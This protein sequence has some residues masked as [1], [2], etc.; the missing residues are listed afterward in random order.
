MTEEAPK[1]TKEQ[2]ARQKAVRIRKSG[3]DDAYSWALFKDGYPI[4]RGM[5]RREA[6]WRRRRY[7]NEGVL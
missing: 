3:G 6:E 2:R 7:I 1:L 5:D 4:Y